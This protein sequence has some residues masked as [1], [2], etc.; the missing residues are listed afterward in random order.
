MGWGPPIN[1]MPLPPSVAQSAINA[2]DGTEL[3]LT[4]NS[5]AALAKTTLRP[6][7]NGANGRQWAPM[8]ADGG[9]GD[10][11]CWFLFAATARE[12]HPAFHSRPLAGLPPRL[13]CRYH[14][15][16]IAFVWPNK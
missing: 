14:L 5:A 8:G 1:G 13:P 10:P 2:L 4:A 6:G 7:T 3:V 15:T 9:Q 12:G 16:T 11:G